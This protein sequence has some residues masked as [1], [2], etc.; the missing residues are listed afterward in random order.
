MINVYMKKKREKYFNKLLFLLIY[1]QKL[2][3]F[4]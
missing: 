2:Y 4:N 3:Q 1:K